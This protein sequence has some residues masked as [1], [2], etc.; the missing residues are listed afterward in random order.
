MPPSPGR[1]AAEFGVPV[2]SVSPVHGGQDSSATVW[3]GLL[4]DGSSVAVKATRRASRSALLVQ[5]YLAACDVPGIVAPLFAR[6]GTPVIGVDDVEVSA[7]PWISGR[8][9]AAAGLSASHSQS[10]GEMLARVHRVELP[11]GLRD[12]VQ[13]ARFVP[14]ALDAARNLQR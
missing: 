12:Q 5:G 1:I 6:S 3:R 10:L 9:G 13:S 4:T 11:V 8:R 2:H 7:Q 14:E